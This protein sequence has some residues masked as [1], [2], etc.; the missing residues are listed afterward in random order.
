MRE[1]SRLIVISVIIHGFLVTCT[2]SAHSWT[3][4]V[5][6]TTP[7]TIKVRVEYGALGA[8]VHEAYIEPCGS[9]SFNTGSD[10]GLNLCVVHQGRDAKGKCSGSYIINAERCFA[11]NYSFTTC[12]HACWDTAWTIVGTRPEDINRSP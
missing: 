12:M 8:K 10:C 3:A 1:V 2:T 9:K 7:C 11:K 6:N 5:T 4:Y